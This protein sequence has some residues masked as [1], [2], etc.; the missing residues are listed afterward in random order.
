M[1][2]IRIALINL[3]A[4]PQPTLPSQPKVIGGLM[5]CQGACGEQI[6]VTNSN[7][8]YCNPCLRAHR[9]EENRVWRANRREK[10]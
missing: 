4:S 10:K 1:N 3:K 8:R 6:R 5:V 9:V 2:G 7:T